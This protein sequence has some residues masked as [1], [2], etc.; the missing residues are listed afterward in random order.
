MF[1]FSL[2]DFQTRT[3][4]P[5]VVNE[6]Q[7]TIQNLIRTTIDQSRKYESLKAATDG[8][9]CLDDSN[10]GSVSATR[11]L[12]AAL[13]PTEVPD[14]KTGNVLQVP[15]EDFALSPVEDYC[16]LIQRLI[17]EVEDKRYVIGHDMSH[18]IRDGVIHIH[19]RETRL[20]RE[21]YGHKELRDRM[22]ENCWRLAEMAARGT[23]EA[24]QSQSSFGAIFGQYDD[25][26]SKRL[27]AST[28]Q[29]SS[30]SGSR[31]SLGIFKESLKNDHR[32]TMDRARAATFYAPIQMFIDCRDDPWSPCRIAFEVPID[33]EPGVA[34][35]KGW[36]QSWTYYGSKIGIQKILPSNPL[37]HLI[38]YTRN[39]LMPQLPFLRSGTLML[40]TDKSH[41]LKVSAS[42]G[43]LPA[44]TVSTDSETFVSAQSEISEKD[45]FAF[46]SLHI[47]LPEGEKQEPLVVL[48]DQEY[49]E[50]AEFW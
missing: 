16:I 10:N 34:E 19:K 37:N 33:Q 5:S 12:N 9:K 38:S 23:E 28:S 31:D 39:E 7:I 11:G 50:P 6:Q 46:E 49:S 35:E 4:E 42:S 21:T 36:L 29:W 27:D 8:N 26:V 47:S 18:R 20:L 32:T 17:T 2:A 40:V 24:E 22:P 13:I 25:R 15:E 3:D 45:R 44:L 43:D 41:I 1:F 14:T 48:G 30:L